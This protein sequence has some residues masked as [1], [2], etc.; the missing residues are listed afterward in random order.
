MLALQGKAGWSGPVILHFIGIEPGTSLAN[1]S[2]R[3]QLNQPG[4]V[5]SESQARLQY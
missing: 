2:A 1:H 3:T 5:D 4:D